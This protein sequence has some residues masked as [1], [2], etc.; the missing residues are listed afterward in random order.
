MSRRRV[1]AE[2]ERQLL[3]ERVI[4]VQHPRKVVE[5]TGFSDVAN[6]SSG[7]TPLDACSEESLRISK[8]VVP[9]TILVP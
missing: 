4:L 6:L 8:V 9:M 3:S 1:Q 7:R 2:A 5:T